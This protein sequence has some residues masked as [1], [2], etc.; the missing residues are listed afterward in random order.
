MEREP[1]LHIFT[2]CTQEQYDNYMK[3]LEEHKKQKEENT[4]VTNFNNKP[5]PG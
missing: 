1:K 4:E 3:E 2:S 5:L